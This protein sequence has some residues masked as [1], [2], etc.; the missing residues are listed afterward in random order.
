MPIFEI[1]NSVSTPI[2]KQTLKNIKYFNEEYDTLLKK[3][4][5]NR[6]CG[7]TIKAPSFDSAYFGTFYI[8]S[9]FY[10]SDRDALVLSLRSKGD[11]GQSCEQHLFVCISS[12]MVENVNKFLSGNTLNSKQHHELSQRGSIFIYPTSYGYL[13]IGSLKDTI[14]QSNGWD[15]VAILLGKESDG[16]D[17]TRLIDERLIEKL[18]CDHENELPTGDLYEYFIKGKEIQS[19]FANHPA[20]LSTVRTFSVFQPSDDQLKSKVTSPVFFSSGKLLPVAEEAASQKSTEFDRVMPL[21]GR[22]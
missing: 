16:K 14:S 13:F 7:F 8:D 12:S 4:E 20:P 17:N 2:P 19:F 9:I 3:S 21:F 10:D 15:A 11:K 18:I 22:E 1:K 6:G 5:Q